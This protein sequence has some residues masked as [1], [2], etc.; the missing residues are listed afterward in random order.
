MKKSFSILFFLAT[1]FSLQ[2]QDR[3][4][5][6]T[7]T[8]EKMEGMVGVIITTKDGSTGTQSDFDGSYSIKVKDS[9][10]ILVFN[11]TGYKN[12]EIVVGKD[13]IINV[14][15]E[16]DKETLQE[17]VSIGYST[18]VRL[19][20]GRSKKAKGS[21][22][23]EEQP[24]SYHSNSEEYSKVNENIFANAKVKPI[25]TFS[26]DV[27]VASYTNIRRFLNMGQKP[28]KDAVRVEEMINYFTYDYP[29]PVDEHPFSINT[30]FS[31]CPWNSKH[32]LLQIGLQGKKIPTENLPPSNLVFLIDV[33][34]SMEPENRLPLLKK[35]FKL[36]VKQLRPKDQV[37]IVVYSGAAGLVLP[38]TSGD[39]KEKIN[40][41][42]DNLNAGGSTAGGDGIQ[43]AY[44]IAM[45]NFLKNGNN[46]IILATDGDFNVG[47]SN[48]DELVKLIEE[49]RES[50]VFLTCLGFGMGNYKDSKLE[51]LANKGNGNYAYIDNLTE[52]NKVFVNEFGGTLFTIAKDVKIQIEFNPAN[53]QGYRLIGYEN[54][55]LETEDF[56][57]DKKDAGELGSGHT[58][59]ALYEIVPVGV[60]SDFLKSEKASKL[61]YKKTE[62]SPENVLTD[63]LLTVKFRYKEP[64]GSKSNEIIKVVKNDAIPLDQTSENYRFASA[65]AAFGML[66]YDS[67]FKSNASYKQVIQLAKESKGKD[68]EGYRGEMIRL[69]KTLE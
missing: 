18:K 68:P 42:I 53:V 55:I 20:K 28:P 10:S 63:E 49:K 13:S 30:E 2:A 37:S 11:F 14:I 62:A 50:G 22:Q 16:E 3:I 38:P 5:T 32:N 35:A 23:Y 27:D 33:S 64:K 51:K 47:V 34:G 59:T 1:L 29:Q 43:L 6:G 56:E 26:I 19:F 65:V 40:A 46:R 12:K 54:R 66:L 60:E 7:I 44:E 48:D 67:P 21:S 61:K 4:I 36:L 69:V 52:A 24:S 45:K 39:K 58:V 25:S 15:L 41:A 31:S 57:D 17:L 9:K 8:D